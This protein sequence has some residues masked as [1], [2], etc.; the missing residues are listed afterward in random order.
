[1]TDKIRTAMLKTGKVQ[2]HDKDQR[3]TMSDEYQY[4]SS[5]GY[6]DAK[7][8]ISKGYQIG[9][10]YLIS[11]ELSSHIQRL[12]AKEVIYYKLTLNLTDIKTGLIVWSDEKELKKLFKKRSY[13]I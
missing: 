5:S 6:V 1:M 8:A 4:Q 7:T 9:T 10:D 13:A 12:G 3:K 2:F 11:G